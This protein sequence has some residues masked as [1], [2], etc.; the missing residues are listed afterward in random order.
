M[1][2]LIGRQAALGIGRE[3][4]RGTPVAPAYWLPK[5]EFSFDEKTNTITVPA[6][7]GVLEDSDQQHV[8]SKFAEGDIT[9]QVRSKSFGLLSY[10]ML[11]SLN[12]TGPSDSAYTHSFSLLNSVSHPSLTFV[13]VDPNSTDLYSLVMLNSL[14]LTQELENVLM[15]SAG[16]MGRTSKG[17]SAT[18]SYVTEAKFSKTHFSLKLADDIAGLAAA[19]ALS[20]KSINLA[21]T[22]NVVADDALGTA[23]PEDFNNQVVTVEGSMTLNYGDQTFKEYM[24]NNTYKS[25]Q[26]Q[27]VNTDADA[28]IGAA[29]NP[30]L[31]IQLP[32]VGFMEWEPNYALDEIVTQTIQFKAYYDLTNSLNAISLWRLINDVTSY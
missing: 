4:T 24:R 22:K 16:F 26:L 13:V 18:A 3:T 17:S 31:T 29:T 2:K 27:W 9:G 25:M 5:T 6:S 14:E 8:L 28:V 21:V 19:S 32:R 11:G 20:I 12:T 30:S 7:L 23:Q 1:A 10:A 15:F